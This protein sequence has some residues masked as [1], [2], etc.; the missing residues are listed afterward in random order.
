MASG[1][2]IYIPS[3]IEIRS[4]TQ[5]LLRTTHVQTYR[6]TESKVIS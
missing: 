2:N 6:H 3:L 1:T 5:K 4:G